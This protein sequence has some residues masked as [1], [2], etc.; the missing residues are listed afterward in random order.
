MVQSFLPET[1]VRMRSLL[2]L[3]AIQNGEYED[4]LSAPQLKAG[5]LINEPSLLFAKINDK[6]DTSR[7]DIIEKQKNQLS[8]ILDAETPKHVPV[9]DEIKF[10]DF[11]KLD[12]R[13]GKVTAAEKMEKSEKLLKLTVDLGFEQRTILSRIAKHYTPEDITGK[14][15]IIVANLAPRKM[16]GI[17]SEGMVLMAEDADGQLNLVNTDVENFGNGLPI[18]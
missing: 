14:N 2:K 1:S 6:K 3:D 10:D 4:I 5:H 16:M 7:L 11:V 17:M 13:T 8:A 18:S 9:K 15:V 12:L